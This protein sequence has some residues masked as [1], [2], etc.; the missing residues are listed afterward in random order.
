M[1][2]VGRTFRLWSSYDS[3]RR[4]ERRI[5]HCS[6]KKV[7][8]KPKGSSWVKVTHQKG[9]FCVQPLAGSSLWAVWL[10]YT[11]VGRLWMQQLRSPVNCI[12]FS[13]GSVCAYL[14]LPKPSTYST[15]ICFFTVIWREASLWFPWVCLPEGKLKREKFEL[16]PQS[17]HW[18]CLPLVFIPFLLCYPFLISFALSYQL[19]ISCTYL[20]FYPNLHFWGSECLMIILFSGL[21]GCMYLFNEARQYQEGLTS[22]TWVI[23][24]FL[25]APLCK[26][27]P[28]LLLPLRVNYP[29]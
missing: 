2:E 29:C 23:Q 8:G 5:L 26:M 25:P 3:F 10:Q 27:Q 22:I 16:K 9:P 6:L 7:L 20:V 12:I 19:S 17:L 13:N 28:Y 21:N 4:E 1:E 14:W 11:H 15:Q 18:S 24:V